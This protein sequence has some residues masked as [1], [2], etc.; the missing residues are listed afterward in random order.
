V[1]YCGLFLYRT[2]VT[3]FASIMMMMMMRMMMMMTMIL[4]YLD[5]RECGR[6]G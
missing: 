3:W 5:L 4:A 6:R 2:Q 1:S